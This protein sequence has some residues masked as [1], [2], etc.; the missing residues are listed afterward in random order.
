LQVLHGS[1]FF[2]IKIGQI[3]DFK[4]E[5]CL[6]FVAACLPGE[7]SDVIVKPLLTGADNSMIPPE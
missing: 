4:I 5:I 3:V 2:Y 1:A 7:P 6:I